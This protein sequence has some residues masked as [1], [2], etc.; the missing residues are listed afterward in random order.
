MPGTCAYFD[1]FSG[2][3]G[4]MVLGALIDAGVGTRA[5]LEQLDL[6]NLRGWSLETERVKR[7]GLAAT[8]AVVRVT[9]AVT[10]R[11]L[12]DILA[13]VAGSGLDDD[14]KRRAAAVFERLA[15]CEARV[16]GVR[17]EEVFLHELSGTDTIIDVAGALAGLKILGVEK[18]LSSPLN[19][20]AGFVECS[21]GVL[22]VP[23]PGTVEILR[24]VPVFSRFDGELTTPTGAA[25]I[26]SL[27]ED[28]R[29]LPTMK[30]LATG[31]GAGTRDAP[32]PNVLR[33]FLGDPVTASG[34]ATETICR[35]QTNIDDMDPRIY[36][37]LFEKV[38]E[39]GALEFYL[40]PVIMKKNRPGVLL[41]L[42]CGEEKVKDMLDLLVKETPTL[43]IRLQRVERTKLPRTTELV[44]TRYGAARAKIARFEG[45][46]VNAAPEYEDC[47][48][49]ARK[50][51]ISLAEV[52]REV[53]ESA[54]RTLAERRRAG[55]EGGGK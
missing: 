30:I 4:N 44:E 55:S 48:N 24:G 43:G 33:L 45:A 6:L 39:A 2:V 46:V 19:L 13:L 29:P 50:T 3:S 17:P 31:C 23:A 35:L 41:D 51:G 47:A 18:V 7:G 14:L 37:Y 28:F 15:A 22:P 20:G 16:H 25:L 49:I 9:D 32:H 21:H 1:C 52:M 54:V 27:A 53:Q 26:A 10:E 8:H 12:A 11:R 5:L 36:S 34:F 42:L 40:T 38:F